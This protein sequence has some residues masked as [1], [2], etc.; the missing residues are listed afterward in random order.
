MPKKRHV[1]LLV[2]LLTFAVPLAD[3]TASAAAT[4]TA[5]GAGTQKNVKVTG[6][7]TLKEPTA[8]EHWLPGDTHNVRWVYTGVPGNHVKV[9]LLRDGKLVEVLTPSVP[10]GAEGAGV[11]AWAISENIVPS[12]NYR[13]EI[14]SLE[15][16]NLKSTSSPFSI[17]GKI[18]VT[19][20]AGELAP[21][22]TGII[23]W[24]YDGNP[25]K[26]VKIV[27]LDNG[28]PVSTLVSSVTIGE[29]GKGIAAWSIP[30]TI[31]QK[32]TY[33]VRVQSLENPLIKGNSALISFRG[34]IEVDSPLP[35]Q[36]FNQPAVI[37]VN[38]DAYGCGSSVKI[39]LCLPA[40]NYT[41]K[42]VSSATVPVVNNKFSH[43]FSISGLS[44]N[45]IYSV[46]VT[47][48]AHPDIK[49]IVGGLVIR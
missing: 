37:N 28:A 42:E 41:I 18:N 39:T 48:I 17:R 49:T 36:D 15:R 3:Y 25:G 10:M 14:Q 29:G 26:N 22:M 43:S 19:A 40:V 27:L 1:F 44:P 23:R 32:K 11:F 38:G 34:K 45:I 47:S 16:T 31:E 4:T 46:V 8:G 24:T 5:Q 20:P 30:E 7:I 6:S 13:I 12:D 9:S 33:T 2:L 21:G 35:G